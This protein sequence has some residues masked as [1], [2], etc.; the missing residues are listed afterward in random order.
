MTSKEKV[1]LKYLMGVIANSEEL[2]SKEDL[3]KQTSEVKNLVR[4]AIINSL[5]EY[6]NK[7]YAAGGFVRDHLLGRTPKDLDLVVDD[8][9]KKMKSAEIF[10]NKLV[11]V[12]GIRSTNNPHLL[13]EAYGIWGVSLSNPKSYNKPFIYNGVDISGY[14]IEITPPRKEGP[15]DMKKRE[16]SYVEYTSIEDDAKRRDL[17]VNAL[18]QNMVTGEVKDFVGGLKDLKEKKLKPPEHPEG[19]KKIYEDDP[20]R[21]LRIVR[22]KGK[23]PGFE[24]DEDTKKEIKNFISDPGSKELIETKLSKE[25]I[26]GELENILTNPDANTVVDGLN[27]MKD[28]GMI[29]YVSPELEKLFDIYHDTVHHKGESVWEHTMDVLRKTPPTLKARLSALFHDIGKLATKTEKV[30]KEG[31]NR[32]QF[33]DHEK[34]SAVLAEKILKDLKFKPDVIS[35]VKNI[36]HSHM[37]FKNFDNSGKDTQNRTM[38]VFIEKLFDDLSDAISLLKADSKEENVHKIDKLDADI[39]VVIEE[40]KKKGI[41]VEREIK[42]KDRIIKK[43]EYVKPLTGDDLMEIYKLQGVSIGAVQSYLKKFILTGEIKSPDAE[44]RKEEAKILIDR[45]MKDKKA[46]DSL[47]KKYTE[48]SKS[49]DFF[50]VRK[51]SVTRVLL[52]YVSM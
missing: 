49:D 45:L 38:R 22:F 1:V 32:V 16:P 20:L 15:Y 48:G 19:I 28:L 3:S 18:Y 23:L 24:I 10:A 34:H 40:D 43:H 11:D 42:T 33:I 52:K 29:K 9:K 13:K 12:L 46:F 44:G 7:V 37:G 47:V 25:R 21:F 31:R 5:P 36:V 39:K 50:S 41:L 27:S 17:T 4:D 6:K 35:A 8:P 14:V 30:D 51:S 26:S 2:V